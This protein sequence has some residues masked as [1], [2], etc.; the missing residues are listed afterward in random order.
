MPNIICG[1]NHEVLAGMP[2]DTYDLTITSPPYDDMRTYKGFTLNIPALARQLYRTTKPGGIVVWVVA[3]QTK[4]HNMSGTSFRHALKFQDLGFNL[5]HHMIYQKNRNQVGTS[6]GAYFNDFE[7]MFV[8]SKGKPKTYNVIRD[9]KNTQ[10]GRLHKHHNRNTDGTQRYDRVFEV[11]ELGKRGRIWKYITGLYHSSSDKVA[12]EHPAIFPEK[13]AADH[14][15]TWTNKGDLVLDPF[16][17]SG[18]TMKMALQLGREA[19]GIDISPEYC[20]IAKRRI[21]YIQSGIGVYI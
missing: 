5:Y 1:N 8:F 13:L 15:K 2:D 18:T 21:Q 14:I 19:D 3:D 17:G 12:F 6:I 16:V 9:V 20:D 7:N 10:S 4:D 11:D